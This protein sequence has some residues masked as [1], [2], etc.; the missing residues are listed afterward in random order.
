M[1]EIAFACAG[2]VFLGFAAVLVAVARRIW[3]MG[4]D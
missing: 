2:A 3:L 4:A 1:E